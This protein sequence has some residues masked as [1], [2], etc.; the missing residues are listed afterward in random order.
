V[1]F[2]DNERFFS[3]S[4]VIP[5]L[6][7]Q[8]VEEGVKVSRAL[9][10]GG[11]RLHEITLR[12][13][14]GIETITALRKEIPGLIVGAGSVL[15]AEMGQAAIAAGA[16]FLVS[17]GT[18]EAL[19]DFA[20]S[21]TVPF[22]PGAGSVSEAMRLLAMGCTM[23]KLFPAEPLGGVRFLQAIAGPLASM[24]FC[25][26]GGIHAANAPDYLKLANVTA[27]GGSWMAPGDLVKAK[28]LSGI[29]RL[30][31]QAASL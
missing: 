22:L 10:E 5:V 17:P 11:L 3:K 23:T 19:L 2:A 24:K 18:T 13:A 12:T 6:T 15:T 9:F 20:A 7:P 8:S 14:A 1:S 21:C 26:T 25:P 31:E 16:S 30:A 27:V 4:R 28:D 29:R